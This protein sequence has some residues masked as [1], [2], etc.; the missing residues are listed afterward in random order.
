M[1]ALGVG[2]GGESVWEMEAK[3]GGG[4]GALGAWWGSDDV[5]EATRLST[6]RCRV[7]L[8]EADGAMESGGSSVKALEPGK[9]LHCCFARSMSSRLMVADEWE[10]ACDL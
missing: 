4:G 10:C 5:E 1:L 3:G 6:I 7:V 8:V 9:G 2:G